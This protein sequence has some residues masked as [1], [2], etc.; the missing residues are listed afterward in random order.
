MFE[1]GRVDICVEVFMLSSSLAMPREVH[2]HQ[3]FHIFAYLKK[4]HN[5]KIVFD[6]SVPDF[7][8]EKF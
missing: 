2:L 4:H 7:D 3:L 5:T 6:L 8:A 1:L